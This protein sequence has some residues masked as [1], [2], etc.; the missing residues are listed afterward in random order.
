VDPRRPDSAAGFPGTAH[1]QAGQGRRSRVDNGSFKYLCPVA[2]DRT[3][4]VPGDRALVPIL[5]L[6]QDRF[7][8]LRYRF[9]AHSLVA[10]C[11]IWQP[12]S[13]V[14]LGRCSYCKAY[15]FGALKAACSLAS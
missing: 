8:I 6:A 3:D 10:G 5:D 7:Q 14:T 1:G 13:A 12:P 2:T 15:D 11:G 9:R 4:P